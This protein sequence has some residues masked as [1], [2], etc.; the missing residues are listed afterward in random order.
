MPVATETDTETDTDSAM[1]SV[2]LLLMLYGFLRAI[3]SVDSSE[4]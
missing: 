4:F 2:L 1:E 3:V